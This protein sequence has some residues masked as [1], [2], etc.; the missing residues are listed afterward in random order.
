MVSDHSDGGERTVQIQIGKYILTFNARMTKLEREVLGIRSNV[1]DISIYGNGKQILMLDCDDVPS[2]VLAR[3]LMKIQ[4]KFLLGDAEVLTSSRKTVY[5]IGADRKVP[6][7]HIRKKIVKKRHVYFFQDLMTYWDAIKVIH[8]A[9]N[10]LGIADEAF[11]RWRMI[12][13]NM[14]L[15][16]SP[17]TKTDIPEKEFVILS[18]FH[19]PDLK[20]FKDSVYKMIEVENGALDKAN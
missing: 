15:R 19:K 8:Y 7:L 17:K 9:T 6:F 3:S 18:P 10:V 12:R 4:H 14:V 13:S 2:D 1:D 20:W 16:I 11:A 5:S